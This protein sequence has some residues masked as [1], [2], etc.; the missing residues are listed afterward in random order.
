LMTRT[1]GR[2]L[3]DARNGDTVRVANPAT[4]AVVVGVISADGVV[5]AQ[6][7]ER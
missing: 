3:A 2:L 4:G 6:G 5:Q 1:S 7:A